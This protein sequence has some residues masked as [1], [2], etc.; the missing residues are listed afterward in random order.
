MLVAARQTVVALRRYR[1]RRAV[2]ADVWSG[3]EDA[4]TVYLP[5]KLA[6]LVVLEPRL[7]IC[8]VRWIARRGRRGP[9]SFP[10]ARRSLFPLVAVVVLFTLP[11]EVLVRA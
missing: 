3:L 9:G 6:R 10:Y 2:G 1:G 11:V 5:R 8:L 4:V 7:W